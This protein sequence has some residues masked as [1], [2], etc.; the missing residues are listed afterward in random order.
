MRLE[1]S[2]RLSQGLKCRA[3]DGYMH[4]HE[5]DCPQAKLAA[6]CLEATLRENRCP[7]C[8]EFVAL[9]RDDF[10]ECRKCHAQFA[11]GPACGE[12]AET[13]EKT[14]LVG[15]D[16]AIQVVVMT[17]KG[18]GKFR[19]DAIIEMLQRQV[20]EAIER[21]EGVRKPRKRTPT[22]YQRLMREIREEERAKRPPK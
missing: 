4:D 2:P 14:Y 10:F 3:C 6:F 17:A 20:E 5:A 8:H 22:V 16:I 19:D 11:T 9:N 1:L 13:L 21:R 18:Q 15:G 7:K 12:V